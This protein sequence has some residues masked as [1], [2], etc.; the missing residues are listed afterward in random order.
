MGRF[1]RINLSLLRPSQD[2]L[3]QEGVNLYLKYIR[4]GKTLAP[5]PVAV[6]DDSVVRLDCH[7][8]CAAQ[9]H[10]TDKVDIWLAD[11]PRDKIPSE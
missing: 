6:V 1:S 11:G 8:Q 3:N 10:I 4:K 9:S 7:H 2:Y 5:I